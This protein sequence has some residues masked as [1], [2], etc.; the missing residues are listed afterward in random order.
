MKYFFSKFTAVAVI[1]A[2]LAVNAQAQHDDH[3]EMVIFDFNTMEQRTTPGGVNIRPVLLDDV[4][5]VQ[6]TLSEGET[7]TSHSHEFEQ[8]VVVHSGQIKAFSGDDEF[9]LGPGQG[10]AA[11]SNVHHY[12][13]ALEDSVTIEVIGPGAP[14]GGAPAPSE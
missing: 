13:M 1:F 6:V 12:Y 11:A 5:L 7:I 3:A 9:I 10:F 14:N 8:M 2:A 4:R